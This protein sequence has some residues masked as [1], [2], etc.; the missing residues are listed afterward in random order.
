MSGKQMEGDN[1][2]RRTLAHRTREQGRQPSEAEATLGSS[3]QFEHTSQGRRSGPPPAGERKPGPRRVAATPPAPPEQPP[4]M[5]DWVAEL[6]AGPGP[7]PVG[8]RGFVEDVRQRLGL[9]FDQ[10]RRAAE[11]TVI[12]LARALDGPDRR[13]LLDVVPAALHDDYPSVTP[14]QPRTLIGFLD[15]VARM[16]LR[17]RDQARYQAQAV[18]NALADHRADLIAS[19]DIPPDLR[20][21]LSPVAAGGGLVDKTAHVAPLTDDEVR[22]ALTELPYW[23]GSRNAL[24]RALVLPSDNL[25]RVI[26]RLDRLHAEM[27]RRPHVERRDGTAMIV[28]RTESVDAVTALDV[29]LAHAVDDAIEEVGAGIA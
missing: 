16:T 23:S 10:A 4:L 9:D 15:D 24:V 2:R 27:G 1:Q 18:L 22:S 13:R 6:P 28:V 20:E 26:R 12:A 14:R 17:P 25:D 3:K 29:D 5:D 8:Y 21:L 19:L 7:A 11:A